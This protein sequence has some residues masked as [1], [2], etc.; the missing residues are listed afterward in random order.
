MTTE[1]TFASSTTAARHLTPGAFLRRA[2]FRIPPGE[3]SVDK[4][5]FQVRDPSI[6][7][8][9]E[10][11]GARF[12][13]SFNLAI[14]S[15]SL[16]EMV[17]ALDLAEPR[18]RGFGYEGAAMGLAVRDALGPGP[19]LWQSFVRGPAAHQ[20][21]ISVV[22]RG[23]ALARLP[24]PPSW[25]LR[26]LTGPL[27]WLAFDGY[28]FH[29]GFFDWRRSVDR[30]RRSGRFGG[31]AARAFDQGLGR[32]LWFVRGADTAA[33]IAAIAR[34]DPSRQADLWA[35]VGLA[36]T[37]A[38]GADPQQLSKLKEAS[39]QHCS[40][41]R[42]GA[43]FAAEAR[44]KAGIVTAQTEAALSQLCGLDVAQAS[45]LAT[46]TRPPDDQAD[47]QG[48]AYDAWRRDIQRHFE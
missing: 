45:R 44:F 32:S 42:Q 12:V 40:A 41:L 2:L 29:E 33:I 23:W 1:P 25:H 35:G 9:I 6:R 31:Y 22:G 37:Y 5:G 46:Q 20:E 43:V 8:H 4:R 19:S 36:A 17:R 28:G 38:A 7:T 14:V 3:A 13:E 10:A 24:G 15:A 27:R 30:C 18:Y 11:I 26:N 47:P 21:Y 39:G 34:F 48:T 16:D